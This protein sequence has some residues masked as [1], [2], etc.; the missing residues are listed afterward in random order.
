MAMH[1]AGVC[2]ASRLGGGVLTGGGDL[3]TS[4]RGVCMCVR[5]GLRGGGGAQLYH[6]AGLVDLLCNVGKYSSVEAGCQS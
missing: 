4:G 6:E 2:S 3:G 1:R 5:W